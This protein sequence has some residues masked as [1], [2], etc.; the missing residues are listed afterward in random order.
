MVGCK[1][2]VSLAKF[3]LGYSVLFRSDIL[4]LCIILV[5]CDDD[6]TF[7]DTSNVYVAALSALAPAVNHYTIQAEKVKLGTGDFVPDAELIGE[8]GSFSFGDS[9][10]LFTEGNFLGLDVTLL[11]QKDL[12]ELSSDDCEIFWR[13][14]RSTHK[15]S[16]GYFRLSAVGFNKTG[17]EAIFYVS[18]HGGCLAGSGSLVLMKRDGDRWVVAV[19][20][21][22]WVS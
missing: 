21:E 12:D 8:Y 9:N 11:S 13:N 18:G 3:Q 5:G 22:L 4:V 19:H 1:P 16:S 14:F 20:R 7:S 15:Q 2:H 6:R 17:T 10:S